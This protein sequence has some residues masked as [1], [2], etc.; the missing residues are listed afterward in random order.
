M[1]E[2]KLLFLSL[3]AWFDIVLIFSQSQT[4]V[5]EKFR[6]IILLLGSIKFINSTVYNE[7]KDHYSIQI[8]PKLSPLNQLPENE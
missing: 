8:C 7:W 4:K 5:M 3:I 2:T 6:N 1:Q